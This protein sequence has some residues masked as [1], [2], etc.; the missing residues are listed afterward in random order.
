MPLA[1]LKADI[2]AK[3]WESD[4]GRFRQAFR[5]QLV[6]PD[7]PD[8]AQARKVWNGMIDVRPT[9]IAYCTGQDDVATA[10]N[11]ARNRGLPVAV[12]GS[13]HGISGAAVCEGGLVIDVSRMK[14]VAVDRDRM[15]V[16]AE[17][18]LNLGEFDS[19]TQA[20]GL[21][22]TMGVNSDTGMTGLALGGGIGK[23][24]RKHGLACDNLIAAE[25]VTADGRLLKASEHE[26]PDLLWGLRGGGGNF[27]VVTALEFRLHRVGPEVLRA[28]LSFDFENAPEA[29]SFYADIC[30]QAPN[31]VCLDAGLVFTPSG[32]PAFGFSACHFGPMEQGRAVLERL[33]RPIRTRLAALDDQTAPARYLD[34]QSAA[35]PIFPRGRRFYWKAQF[36]ADLPKAAIAA[37]LDGFS[38]APS[39]SSLFVFQHVGGAVSL[40]APDATAY[41]NRSALWDS[42][43]I[44]IWDDPA[45]DEKNIRWARD[46]WLALHPFSTG[47]VY[48]N[49]LGDEGADRVR[50]AYGDNY[51][52][53]AAL[54]GK[55]DPTN[56][57][58]RNQNIQPELGES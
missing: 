51:P 5:G 44:A 46:L 17:A 4:L 54:K 22:T 35:D 24:A 33:L 10:I 47:G 16:R 32:T 21:A 42:F 2:G 29:L 7:D 14:A 55:Y 27:G 39:A 58:C 28:S 20:V 12:R 11:F 25:I 43:P 41:V 13:G 34:I 30:Q 37:L 1:P 45:D 56:F 15:T 49:N 48:V 8:Y 31:E 57:F 38:Q 52:R 40:V 26:N 6:R 23:L 53:L 9:L 18:G 50:A 3:D 19:A 36:L